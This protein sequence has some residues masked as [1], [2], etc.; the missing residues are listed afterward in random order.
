MRADR[1]SLLILTALVAGLAAGFPSTA[2]A[3]VAISRSASPTTKSVTTT[4]APTTSSTVQNFVGQTPYLLQGG[5][6][7]GGGSSQYNSVG[8]LAMSLKSMGLS[9]CT[10][11]LISPTWVL[12]AAHCLAIPGAKI[13]GLSFRLNG[14]TYTSRKWFV[15]PA[16]I[17]TNFSAG[18]D[19]ALVQLTTAV[20]GVTYGKL[21]SLSPAIED[22]VSLVG[23]GLAGTGWEGTAGNSG[24]LFP[25]DE[26]FPIGTGA[27]RTSTAGV[28][29]VGSVKLNEVTVMHIA[30]FFTP[31]QT[32]STAPGDSGGPAFNSNGEIVGVCSGGTSGN[33]GWGTRAF[34]TRVDTFNEWIT[35]V[36]GVTVN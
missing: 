7:N 13:N 10:G 6:A 2:S 27:G 4:V 34:H 25:I 33:A 30:W 14:A 8:Q 21:P 23:Y 35:S 1:L 19:I 17:S 9:T 29:R 22:V 11:T 26:L 16:Y 32:S 15:H 5:V 3:Q 28:K 24:I 36:T 12:T 20:T 31:E 18:N